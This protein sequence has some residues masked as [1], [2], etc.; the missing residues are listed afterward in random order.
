MILSV[1]MIVSSTVWLRGM[2]QGPLEWM[3]RTLSELR[4]VPMLRAKI[5]H[6]AASGQQPPVLHS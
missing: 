2:Q 3:W 6:M 5:Q 1:A 4:H